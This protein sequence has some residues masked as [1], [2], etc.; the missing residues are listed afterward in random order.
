MENERTELV[1]VERAVAACN[2]VAVPNPVRVALV[3]D[4]GPV[5][6]RLAEYAEAAETIRVIDKQSADQAASI[7]DRIAA[8]IKTVENHEVVSR[9]TDG[10]YKLH[11]QWT[12]LRDMFVGPMKGNRK[13]IKM[14]V[15]DW[16]AREAAKAEALRAKLQAEAEAKAA[17][18]KAQ[19]EA[20][21]KRQLAIQQEAERKAQ[22]ARIAAAAA[23]GAEKARLEAAANAADR[24]ANAAAVKVEARTEAAANVIAPTIHIDAPKSGMRS[25]GIVTCEIVSITEFVKAAVA[26]PDLCGYIDQKTLA[27]AL[28]TTR[29]SNSMFEV[30][31]VKFGRKTV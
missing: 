24:K 19:E 6:N 17:T 30:P 22:D 31:G 5:A 11:R 14:R 20:E 12:G 28:K 26:R 21:A 16:E 27:A 2:A 10:L 4:L 18:K 1:E 15:T 3:R 9:I 13:T 23:Q 25:Q 8:D 29:I 7:C